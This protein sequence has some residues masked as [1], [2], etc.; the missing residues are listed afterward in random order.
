MTLYLIF[1]TK[2]DEPIAKDNKK[3]LTTILPAPVATKT[4]QKLLTTNKVAAANKGGQ[5]L[6]L[7]SK[8][9]QHYDDYGNGN[10][11]NIGKLSLLIFFFC[12]FCCICFV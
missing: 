4:P 7:N 1:S 11:H 5:L 2:K 3:K 8:Q 10:N 12:S 9:H 6:E